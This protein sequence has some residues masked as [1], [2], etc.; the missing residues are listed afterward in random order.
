MA[1]CVTE[2]DGASK[3]TVASNHVLREATETERQE[4][5]GSGV[6][7]GSLLNIKRIPVKGAAHVSMQGCTCGGGLVA[8]HQIGSGLSR[9]PHLLLN[10]SSV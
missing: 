4:I 3:Q 9:A 2:R 8:S 10:L 5:R 7:F 1:D 6:E